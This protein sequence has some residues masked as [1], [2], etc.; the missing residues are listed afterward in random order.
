[1]FPRNLTLSERVLRILLALLAGWIALYAFQN[2]FARAIAAAAALWMCVEA[3]VG[4]CPLHAGM[5][6]KRPGDAPS[7]DRLYLAIL[8][9]MQAVLAAIWWHAGWEKMTGTFVADLPKIFTRFADGNPYPLYVSFLQS[10]AMPNALAFAL[11]V[12][13]SQLLIA[14]VLAA[15][16]LSLL[17]RHRASQRAALA[18]SI[19]ALLGGALMNANFWLAGGWTG[20][21]ASTSNV[22]LFW[23]ELLLAYAWYERLRHPALRA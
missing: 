16:A 3:A 12:Q 14:A 7:A 17:V 5:G 13:W 20:A 1:M 10:V 9:G 23:P 2:V 19:A 15:C 11:L 21:A 22:A 18:L 4:S 6:V 8:L